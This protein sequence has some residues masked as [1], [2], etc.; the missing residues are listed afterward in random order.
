M[1]ES[2]VR[3]AQGGDQE[4]FRAIVDESLDRLYAVASLMTRDHSLAEDAVQD[5]LVRAWRDLPA[6]R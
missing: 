2:V 5:A 6:L 1:D 4:A 3:R